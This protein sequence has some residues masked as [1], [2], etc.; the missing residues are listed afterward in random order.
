[1]N[2]VGFGGAEDDGVLGERGTGVGVVI[3]VAGRHERTLQ[4]LTENA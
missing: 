3:P 2:L 4:M 1:M